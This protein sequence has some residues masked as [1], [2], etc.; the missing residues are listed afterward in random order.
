M[1]IEDM[2]NILREKVNKQT[3][4]CRA[5]SSKKKTYEISYEVGEIIRVSAEFVEYTKDGV[6]V[7]SNN[8]RS[9]LVC[10]AYHPKFV[11]VKE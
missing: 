11:R 9:E 4:G 6:V 2:Y 1:S 10:I 5:S 8:N 3:C 7:F